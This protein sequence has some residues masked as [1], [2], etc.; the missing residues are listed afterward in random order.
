MPKQS[1]VFDPI[2][3]GFTVYFDV[4]PQQPKSQNTETK[5]STTINEVATESIEP[6]I[7]SSA[8]L[9]GI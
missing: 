6:L 5:I 9:T 7:Y 2:Q 1:E 8:S 4:P 3:Q